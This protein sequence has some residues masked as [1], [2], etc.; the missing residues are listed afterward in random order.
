MPDAAP[1]SGESHNTR[2]DNSDIARAIARGGY[3]KHRVF[4]L[5]EDHA[6]AASDRPCAVC[7]PA[8][9][10]SSKAEQASGEGALAIQ[11]PA[12]Q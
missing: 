4:F 1:F 10:A 11:V 2:G 5:T 3:V 7:F 6:R 12:T 9:Y 8:A